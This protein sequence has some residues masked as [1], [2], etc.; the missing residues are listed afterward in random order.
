MNQTETNL[1]DVS[2]T[3]SPANGAPVGETIEELEGGNKQDGN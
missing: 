3:T 2:P 1:T